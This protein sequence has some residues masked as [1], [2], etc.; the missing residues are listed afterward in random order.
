MVKLVK[1]DQW[2]ELGLCLDTTKLRQLSS[3]VPLTY[4]LSIQD[5]LTA[6]IRCDRMQY[7]TKIFGLD[8]KATC[9][10]M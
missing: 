9:D 2:T 8:Q 6:F 5:Y 10:T 3:H 7:L 4:A 1:L